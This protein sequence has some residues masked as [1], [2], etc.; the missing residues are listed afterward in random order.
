[1]FSLFF[2]YTQPFCKFF[3]SKCKIIIVNKPI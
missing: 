1:M 3:Y 2:L